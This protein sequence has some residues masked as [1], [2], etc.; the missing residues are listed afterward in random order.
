[1]S[2]SPSNSV[3]PLEKLTLYSGNITSVQDYLNAAIDRINTQQ[4]QSEAQRLVLDTFTKAFDELEA[5]Y[6]GHAHDKDGD[7][8]S[9]PIE[10]SHD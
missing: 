3:K 8:T 5:K 9:P 10:A 2:D 6:E 7:S 1:M 4:E